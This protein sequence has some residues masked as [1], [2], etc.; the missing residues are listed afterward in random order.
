MPRLKMRVEI[1]I[2]SLSMSSWRDVK[3]SN[4]YVF[5]AWYLV[6]HRD[7]TLEIDFVGMFNTL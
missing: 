7:F 6:K 4:G 2:H 1:Y 5:V 3:L